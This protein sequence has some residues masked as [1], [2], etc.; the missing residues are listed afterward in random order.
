MARRRERKSTGG[1]TENRPNAWKIH[2]IDAENIPK[3]YGMCDFG[4]LSGGDLV[5]RGLSD[6]RAGLLGTGAIGALG[7]ALALAALSPSAP[8]QAAS[9]TPTANGNTGTPAA[10]SGTQTCTGGDTGIDYTATGGNL[11][12][13]LNNNPL[14]GPIIINDDFSARNLT[15]NDGLASSSFTAA[16]ITSADASGYA[17]ELNSSSGNVNFASLKGG[18]VTYNGTNSGATYALYGQTTGSG[19][20]TL[21]TGDSVTNSDTAST[22]AYGIFGQV[23]NGPLVINAG[24]N[25]SG[26][27]FGNSY[28]TGSV[29]INAGSASAPITVT[30]SNNTNV[31]TLLGQTNSGALNINTWGTVNGQIRGVSSSGPI[32]FNINGNVSQPGAWA[33]VGFASGSSNIVADLNGGTIGDTNATLSGTNESEPAFSLNLGTGNANVNVGDGEIFSSPI[34]GLDV[35]SEGGAVTII[36]GKN[37]KITAAQ[38]TA[39]VNVLG[40][41]GS[42]TFYGGAGIFA[43]S[44][45][46]P[47]SAANTV[48]VTTGSG[49]AIT[50]TGDNTGGVVALNT[51]GGSGGVSVVLGD[52]NSIAMSSGD[53][54][55]GVAAVTSNVTGFGPA[56]AGHGNVSI[57]LGSNDAITL[58]A[59]D[60][61]G[62]VLSYDAGLYAV[63]NGGNVS[64]GWTGTS[65]SVSVTGASG[66]LTYGIYGAT[67]GTGNVSINVGSGVTISSN[68]GPAIYAS[69][70]TGAISVVNNGTVIGAIS[71]PS[72]GSGSLN[73]SGTWELTGSASLPATVSVANPGLI[74]LHTASPAAGDKLTIAGAYTGGGKLSVDAALGTTASGATCGSLADCLQIGSSSGVTSIIV[75]NTNA[76]AQAGL[77]SGGVLIVNGASHAGDFVLDPSSPNYDT[78]GG[79]I[80]EGLIGYSLAYGNNQVRL[81]GGPS[82]LALQLPALI[83]AIEGSFFSTNPTLDRQTFLRDA[84]A[85]AGGGDPST[86]VWADGAVTL[87]DNSNT[88]SLGTGA[89][90]TTISTAYN[91]Q[92][93]RLSAGG[94]VAFNGVAD[95]SDALILGGVA[96]F[97]GSDVNFTTS[98]ANGHV[99]GVQL[100]AYASWLDQGWFVNADFLADLMTLRYA[101]NGAR[102]FTHDPA[103]TALGFNIEAGQR[104]MLDDTLYI[105]PMAA[106]AYAN[107]SA[108]DTSSGSATVHF[109]INNS[110]RG[111]LGARVGT[112]IHT[113]DAIFDLSLSGR[114]WDEFDNREN[115]ALTIAGTALPLSTASVGYY[116]EFTASLKVMS[117]DSGFTGFVDGTLDVNSIFNQLT[118]STGLRYSW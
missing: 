65:G 18:T 36:E 34:A 98:P 99:S 45:Q 89:G 46:T 86:G 38:G 70:G 6:F 108:G 60:G 5:M 26:A 87:G 14:T 49:D 80:D 41:Y 57:S 27:I 50:M 25:I 67:T 24:G 109:G 42:A 96:G 7:I 15:V 35:D 95:D 59:G 79:V 43:Q 85:P 106:L 97:V 107:V 114:G 64:I 1:P 33:V 9:C 16:S 90:A 53:D 117:T 93:Y 72:A 4:R 74:D 75:N 20:V 94:D 100:G 28:G 48:S 73:N 10:A 111:G 8:A 66:I 31:I 101:Q 39:T 52:S 51:G 29:T 88:A 61:A 23:A 115:A 110:L 104:L 32:T 69:T 47:T 21:T 68:N 113:D 81:V 102:L 76:A 91:Q 30:N 77:N 92:S 37:T 17:V 11:I 3:P 116:G 62:G 19:S 112:D 55:F 2:R 103:V 82:P 40:F 13:N 105:E 83:G 63:S 58:G 118:L 22:T 56:F 44:Q 78:N 54:E 84:F 71:I 12:V